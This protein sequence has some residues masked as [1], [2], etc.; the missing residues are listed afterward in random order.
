MNTSRSLVVTALLVAGMYLTE[1]F[2]VEGS[3][4]PSNANTADSLV[5]MSPIPLKVYTTGASNSFEKF[6]LTKKGL[7]SAATAV[8]TRLP[9]PV[10]GTKTPANM[11]WVVN[12]LK[13]TLTKNCSDSDL[14]EACRSLWMTSILLTG[15]TDPTILPPS[16]FSF[17]TVLAVQGADYIT[18]FGQYGCVSNITVS[19]FGGALAQT[20]STCP[21]VGQ[22]SHLNEPFVPSLKDDQYD[23]ARN[24]CHVANWVQDFGDGCL[25]KTGLPELLAVVALAKPAM[26][27][28]R[29]RE[30]SYRRMKQSV[31][32]MERQLAEE[33]RNHGI[34]MGL[35]EEQLAEAE[36]HVNA[37][38]EEQVR[39]GEEEGYA[40]SSGSRNEF[41]R[42]IG[43]AVMEREGVEERRRAIRHQ[44]DYEQYNSQEMSKE[45]DILFERY[46]SA[47]A[48]L[49]DQCDL[50]FR[51]DRGLNEEMLEM[52]MAM[53]ELS[54]EEV[55]AC[56]VSLYMT[57]LQKMNKP[58]PEQYRGG[59]C[60]LDSRIESTLQQREVSHVQEIEMAKMGP[61]SSILETE[62]KAGM[63]IGSV[64]VEESVSKS[65]GD[66][67]LGTLGMGLFDFALD[68]ANM[69]LMCGQV[70]DTV[71]SSVSQLIQNANS[72]FNQTIEAIG[73]LANE[74]Y[75]QY[76]QT[77]SVIESDIR[78]LESAVECESDWATFQNSLNTID[79][80]MGKLHQAYS[81]CTAQKNL[82]GNELVTCQNQQASNIGHKH[83]DVYG[84]V[85]N[86]G[87]FSQTWGQAE[88]GKFLLSCAK[89]ATISGSMSPEKLA[90][91]LESMRSLVD[92]TIR[93]AGMLLEWTANVETR[94]SVS[95]GE[96]KYFNNTP[97]VIQAEEIMINQTSDFNAWFRDQVLPPSLSGYF[98][99]SLWTA[100]GLT[101][102]GATYFQMEILSKDDYTKS[103]GFLS[104]L[105]W[106]P[107]DVNDRAIA[108]VNNG[109]EATVKKISLINT[110]NVT[111]DL[112]NYVSTLPCLNVYCE[113]QFYS[114]EDY[115][116]C[117]EK[118][119]CKEVNVVVT[120]SMS[121][122]Y[123]ARGWAGPYANK[124]E[125]DDPHPLV[126]SGRKLC[127]SKDL[128]T[129]DDCI[130]GVLMRNM[131]GSELTLFANATYMLALPYS[132][133]EKDELAKDD[134]VSPHADDLIF[135]M[136]DAT[137]GWKYGSEAMAEYLSEYFKNERYFLKSI[138][139]LNSSSAS[140]LMDGDNWRFYWAITTSSGL[141]I[142]VR[143]TA[144]A[145]QT[146]SDS[147]FGMSCPQEYSS[148]YESSIQ[149]QLRQTS[150]K[151]P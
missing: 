100:Y 43:D 65:I 37:V 89:D 59:K 8:Y 135:Q 103:R 99:D 39:L 142:P 110:Q 140:Y 133:Y 145:T 131:E 115:A 112:Q 4:L 134:Y 108:A 91:Y 27:V 149:C 19:R 124:T 137:W 87:E 62:A 83:W 126:T 116:K 125:S 12:N 146:I 97:Y 92:R 52:D 120:S 14:K 127:S 64:D 22:E 80:D 106:I 9:S 17:V 144:A 7:A 61:K 30:E 128:E 102:P 70:E 77:Q 96:G 74:S 53:E 119:P 48:T 73:N 90:E 41:R 78:Q 2:L 150:V 63:E 46:Y 67:I 36:A 72:G 76:K 109:D 47:S 132:T 55:S 147:K 56:S 138:F 105:V 38:M 95:I 139:E 23:N 33:N 34:I 69:M 94:Y 42:L 5:G 20:L 21:P 136:Y 31:E 114:S 82:T 75:A 151:Y 6:D 88:V 104:P 148:D 85:A 49:A 35:Y 28:Y 60:N 11:S 16:W 130:P 24:S 54:I 32:Q 84:G 15:T 1:V 81:I 44:L 71:Q 101:P 50:C 123:P 79:T 51:R 18:H 86:Y 25:G 113:Y 26:N 98:P 107:E 68:F 121:T 10:N 57:Y 66:T 111:K 117:T 122:S 93:R 141:Q 29:F 143:V 129:K 3:P 13:P 118:D 40:E 45:Y 58:I